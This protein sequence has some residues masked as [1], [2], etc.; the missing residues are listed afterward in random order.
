MY[1]E[2]TGDEEAETS[3]NLS[4][5]P[6]SSMKFKLN[7]VSNVQIFLCHLT[8]LMHELDDQS[9]VLWYDSVV[10]N[11]QLLWQNTV[12]DRNISFM[13]C[14][15]GIFVNYGWNET[16]PASSAALVGPNRKHE[17]YF[18]IDVFGRGTFGGGGFDTSKA[19]VVLKKAG[20]SAAIFAP[21][22][23]LEVGCNPA[24]DGD[25]VTEASADTAADLAAQA[26]AEGGDVYSFKKT[27]RKF[28]SR[29]VRFWNSV[30]KVWDTDLAIIYRPLK[31]SLSVIFPIS[32]PP[33][34]M[35]IQNV[36][37]HTFHHPFSRPLLT[38]DF[39][40]ATARNYFI[41]GIPF[42]HPVEN[43]SGYFDLNMESSSD[44]DISIF[45]AKKAVD[46]DIRVEWYTK[47]AY[48]G[49]ACVSLNG[50]KY[51]SAG[52]YMLLI[53]YI[54]KLTLFVYF[55]QV[56]YHRNQMCLLSYVVSST[57]T[58]HIDL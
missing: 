18:G 7:L 23:L 46:R 41:S 48:S 44:F 31:E 11:G 1:D 55:L 35:K 21:G 8:E 17:I 16:A 45:H 54:L 2:V 3:D 57:T 26:A 52:V 47:A 27:Y 10:S 20:V 42:D 6:S 24:G 25:D 36:L 38:I 34:L 4:T 50:N 51:I 43:N 56:I 9:T 40:C 37:P 12:N 5:A 53:V 30:S 29:S 32:N 39:S 19:L 15:D 14:C 13:N 22:W 33:E 58:T 49:S 28:S